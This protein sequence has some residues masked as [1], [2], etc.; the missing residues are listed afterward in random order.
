MA[1]YEP[2]VCNIGRDQ[3][4]LRLNGGVASL[5]AAVAYTAWVLGTDQRYQLLAGTFV[6]LAGAIVGYLQYRLQF[7]VAFAA[8][9]RYDLAGSGGDAGT[10]EERSALFQDL[11]RAVQIVVVAV[12]LAALLTFA[13]YVLDVLVLDPPRG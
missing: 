1:E 9:A 4:R 8:L 11:L 3:R 10:V 2:G 5:V 13:L 7:C 12:V 6:L